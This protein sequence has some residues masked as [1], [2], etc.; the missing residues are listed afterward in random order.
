MILPDIN[1]LLYAYNSQAPQHKRAKDW[2]EE[3]ISSGCTLLLPHEILFGFIR[4]ITNKRLGAAS[5]CFSDAKKVI[6]SII[7]LPQTKIILPDSNHYNRVMSLMEDSNSSGPITSDAILA[8]YAIHHR[9]T[10]CS[11]DDDFD[12]FS[13]LT[14]RNPLL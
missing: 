12:R 9:A 14:W 6:D 11:N 8:S 1:L 13:G 7:S 4:I 10:L 3:T 2:L 5:V